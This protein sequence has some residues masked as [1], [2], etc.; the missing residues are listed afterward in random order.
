[1]AT[2]V[3]SRSFV[4]SEPLMRVAHLSVSFRRDSRWVKV[5]D[6][7]SFD[8]QPGRILA[9]VGESGA[10]K[11][12]LAR[13]MLGLAGEGAEIAAERFEI[14]GVSV[15]GDTPRQWR[16][17]RGRQIG[18]ILQDALTSLDPL[19][20]IGAEIGETLDAHRLYAGHDR[21]R[22]VLDAMAEA[23]IPEP[24]HRAR[25]Y[26]G[27]LSGGL[28]QRALIANAIVAN[29]R[30]LI[31]DE[32]TTALDSSTQ[33]QI[34]DLLKSLTKRGAAIL[35]IT[36]DIGVVEEIADDVAVMKEGRIVER[37]DARE[38]LGAPS[39]PYTRSLL[40]ALPEGKPKGV[41]LLA[42]KPAVAA[43][44][45]P[46]SA[47]PRSPQVSGDAI[48][49]HHLTKRYQGR[50]GRT[51]VAVDNVSFRVGHGQT[52][53]LVGGSG[54]GKTTVAQILMGFLN[55]DEGRIEMLG[56]RWS[57]LA[58]KER[59]SR[60]RL[61]QM[62]YQDPLGSFDPRLKVEHILHD[63]L[64][65]SGLKDRSVIR[66][67]SLEL[68][69]FVGLQGSRLTAHPRELS[70]GQ[71]QR[72][73]IARALAPQPS[74]LLCD[75]PVAS[76]DATTQ[77]QVLDLLA[78]IQSQLGLSIVFISHDLGVIQ[79]VA[80]T[81]VVLKDGRVIEQGSAQSVYAA[82]A[83]PYTRELF[84]AAPRWRARA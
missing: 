61:I 15:A 46:A 14:E 65:A 45:A 62:V 82:P 36:H 37:G 38:V 53:G 22:R 39:H 25:Q 28:R 49:A 42:A 24:E 44:A 70:G 21:R 1:M 31:A 58:E 12:V 47:A 48:V 67:R 51:L 17:R 81:I 79:H 10:G 59:R 34:L 33:R 4:D 9:L 43:F 56:A 7:I 32:P 74:I 64:D 41:R 19:R 54:A 71:R 40:A 5:I 20:S 77:A 76:L 68:L 2:N 23:G 80:D 84:A 73:A 60:R 78:D 35:L 52:L 18:M 75:E 26:S 6:N 11:S 57:N 50:D 55:P 16:R 8:L 63:A 30:I 83:H 72:V 13:T 27:Q 69:D 29:P 3:D 66:R